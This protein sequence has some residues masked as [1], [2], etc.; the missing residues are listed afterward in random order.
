MMILIAQNPPRLSLRNPPSRHRIVNFLIDFGR[1][2]CIV[3]IMQNRLSGGSEDG[4]I[5]KQESIKESVVIP[6]SFPPLI[7]KMVLRQP[8][9]MVLFADSTAPNRCALTQK[10]S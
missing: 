8:F 5:P 7:A 2:T 10:G 9:A 1:Q 4:F 3:V 6:V